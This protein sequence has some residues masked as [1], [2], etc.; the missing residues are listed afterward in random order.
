MKTKLILF[1]T[2]FLWTLTA[3]SQEGVPWPAQVKVVNFVSGVPLIGLGDTNGGFGDIASNLQTALEFKEGHP[4]IEVN[5]LVTNIEK[6]PE[7]VRSTNEIMEIMLNEPGK[8][9]T[10]DSTV[11]DVAQIYK[12]IN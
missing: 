2:A 1:L 8:P 6:G 9:K 5:F 4:N 11:K 12:G 7:G 10:L 3:F